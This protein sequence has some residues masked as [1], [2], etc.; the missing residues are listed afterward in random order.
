MGNNQ[1]YNFGAGPAMLPIPVMQQIQEE[2]LDYRGMGVSVIEISHRSKEF[3]EVINRCDEL[4][5]ELFF[6]KICS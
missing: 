5:K 6:L 1:V 4:I 2:F 3:D